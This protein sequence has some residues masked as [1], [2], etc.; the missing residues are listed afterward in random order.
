VGSVANLKKEDKTLNVFSAVKI[1]GRVK[2][3]TGLRIGKH[4]PPQT[5]EKGKI[6]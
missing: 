4:S 1:K 6:H 5:D 2:R 3:F